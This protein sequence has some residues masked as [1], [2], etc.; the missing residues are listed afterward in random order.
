MARTVPLPIAIAI[1]K[2]LKGDFKLTGVA[3]PVTKELYGP[4][5][6]EM[7]TLG[8]IFKEETTPL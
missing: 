7:E 4:I 6:E 8:F 1:N 5:L 3:R 2:I